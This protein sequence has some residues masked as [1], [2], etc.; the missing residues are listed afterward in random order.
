MSEPE[1][2]IFNAIM[3]FY[4]KIL[5]FLALFCTVAFA[6]NGKNTASTGTRI[7]D[8]FIYRLILNNIEAEHIDPMGSLFVYL[9]TSSARSIIRTSASNK[10]DG[11][12]FFVLPDKQGYYN[13]YLTYIREF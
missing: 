5:V 3:C 4:L 10:Y 12:N 2:A 1:F 9:S 6:Q 7:L 8:R 13:V 11:V